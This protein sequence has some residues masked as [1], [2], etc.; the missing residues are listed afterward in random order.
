MKSPSCAAAASSA[1]E[2]LLALEVDGGRHPAQVAVHDAG[3]GRAVELEGCGA[4][5]V[6]VVAL[7]LPARRHA[8]RHVVDGAEHGDHRG[9]VDRHVAGLVVEADVAAGHRDPELE[10]AVGQPLDRLRELPH[11]LGVLGA[12]EVQAVAHRDRGRARDGDVAV[13]LGEGELRS[14][15]RVEVAVPAVRV[16]RHRETEPALL[17]DAHHPAVVRVAQRRVAEHVPV[18]L[19]GDPALVGQVRASP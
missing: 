9:R 16:G 10:A 12:A 2:R 11:D 15:V 18:V 3:P 17:I 19:V 7:V 8:A 13:R 1:P 4:E 5:Q 14:A 6:D